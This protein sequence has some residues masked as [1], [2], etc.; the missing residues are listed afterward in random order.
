M[1]SSPAFA[2]FSSCSSSLCSSPVFSAI[3]SHVRGFEP[4]WRD[5]RDVHGGAGDL[6]A[7][8]V[9]ILQDPSADLVFDF[10]DAMVG[11]D[12]PHAHLQ[13]VVGERPIEPWVVH[14]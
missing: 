12:E 3:C 4:E 10:S 2:S 9:E 1:C 8:R 14:V 5:A 6:K 13:P 11:Y 7:G